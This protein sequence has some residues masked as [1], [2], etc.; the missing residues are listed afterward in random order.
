MRRYFHF[1]KKEKKKRKRVCFLEEIKWEDISISLRNN[2]NNN[3]N[4]KEKKGL[5][6]R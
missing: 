6:I 2:N 5:S 4:N 3:N 1:I